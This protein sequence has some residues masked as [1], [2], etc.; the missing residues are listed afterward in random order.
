MPIRWRLTIWYTCILLVILIILGSSVYLLLDYSLMSQ[1]E[2]DL[3]TKANEVLKSTKVVSTLPF[4]LRQIVL[5]DVD[6]FAAP[7]IYLQVVI[8]NGEIVAR[9]RNLGEYSLPVEKEVASKVFQGNCEFTTFTVDSARFRMVIKPLLLEGEIVGILQVA[10]PLKSVDIA[11]TRL[12]SILFVGGFISLL[13][14]LGL[15]WF[16]SGRVLAPIRQLTD[17]AKTIGEERDFQ[18]RVQYKGARDELGELAV[19]FNA[20]LTGLEDAYKRLAESLSLQKR[21]VADASHELRTPLTSIRGNVDFLLQLGN[22]DENLYREALADI[23]AETKRLNR[24]VGDLLTLAR[25]DS[26]FKLDFT[27]F[28]LIPVLEEVIR[29]ARFWVQGQNFTAEIED[30]QGVI[31]RADADYFKQMLYIFFDNGFKYTP[32]GKNFI[33]RVER[34]ED[35]IAFLFKNEGSGISSQDLPHIFKRFYRS[36]T[37]RAG[38]GTGLGLAIA[39]WIIKEHGGKVKVESEEE[40]ETVFTISFPILRLF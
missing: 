4:F 31:L 10:R 33:F 20:M 30:G 35:Q 18:R 7:D 9:S 24:L 28:E 23:S 14:S 1:V 39:E 27:E 3:Q 36:E 8:K 16:M 38:K 26:G 32:V 25:A 19:T 6:V 2:R 22:K 17:E 13:A 15:G 37:S 34:Q 40:K 29:Q 11:L 21:F 12:Q 5:P